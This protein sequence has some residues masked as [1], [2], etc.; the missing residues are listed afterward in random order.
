M[1]FNVLEKYNQDNLS[2]FE[3]NWLN[4]IDKWAKFKRFGLAL[5]I[6]ETNNPV[7]VVNKQFKHLSDKKHAQNSLAKCL[8]SILSYIKSSEINKEVISNKEKNK[9]VI[10]QESEPIVIEFF[11]TVSQSMAKWLTSQY[12]ASLE[13]LYSLNLAVKKKII[14]NA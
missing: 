4:C 2:Y 11:K 14:I 3:K 9:T 8:A 10:P 13:A 6:Q 5:N 1:E 7:E 12:Q